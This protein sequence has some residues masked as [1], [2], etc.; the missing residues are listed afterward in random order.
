MKKLF[1]AAL[2]IAMV[3][4]LLGGSVNVWAENENTDGSFEGKTLTMLLELSDGASVD[5]TYAQIKAF[6]EK[7]GCTVEVEEIS[8][9]DEGENIR[10]VRLSTGTL[11]DVFTHNIGSNM[12]K[13]DPAENCYDLSG[14]EWIGNVTEGYQSAA[15]LDG[16][17][18][19]VPADTSNV[20]GVFYNKKVFEELQIEIPETWTDLLGVCQTIR[21]AGIDPIT[22]PY[23]KESNTQIPFLANYYYV[24]QENPDF[25]EQYTKREIE[26]TDSKA[27]VGGLQKMYDIATM[28]YLNE[29]YLSTGME[30]CAAMLGEGTAAMMLVRTNIITT[31]TS[32]C[33]DKIDN[34]GFFPIPDENAEVRG[35]SYWMPQGFYVNKSAEEL[36]LAVAW[37]EFI[38]TQEAVDAYCSVVTPCGTFCLNGVEMDASKSYAPVAEAQEWIS[39][40]NC[41]PVMEYSCSI[42]GSNQ[43]TICSMVASGSITAEEA[44]EQI[45]DDN[46]IDAQQKGIEGW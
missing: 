4:T 40:G 38:T 28:D 1:S 43:P 41:T 35:V 14:E 23:A 33:P 20:A 45:A 34:I 16:A 24:L 21:D 3:G 10:M 2:T 22:A 5:G 27:F 42:K 18:Y 44:A 11:A 12:A 26:L 17:V 19:A 25:A 8:G 32:V 37:C 15:S 9:G 7:Y 46:V 36:D 39:G 29:D 6:E 31:M 30:E 13:L